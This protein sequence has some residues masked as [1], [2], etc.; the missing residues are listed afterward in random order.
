MLQNLQNFGIVLISAMLL[1]VG[2]FFGYKIRDGQIQKETTQ[3]TQQTD[4]KADTQ[5]QNQQV[6]DSDRSTK[7]KTAIQ[8]TSSENQNQIFWIKPNNPPNCPETHPIKGK[9][10]GSS[11]LFYTKENK[12]YT[13]VVPIICFATEEYAIQTAG[14]QKKY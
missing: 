14:F 5:S 8:D 7:S 10:D 9:V 12:F 2:G 3:N 6:S 11:G 1:I 4:K 13:R